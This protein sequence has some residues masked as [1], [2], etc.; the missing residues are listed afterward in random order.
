MGLSFATVS[1]GDFRV[2]KRKAKSK[3]ASSM[4]DYSRV[5]KL[6]SHPSS[7]KKRSLS[8]FAQSAAMKKTATED[9]AAKQAGGHTGVKRSTG[10]KRSGKLAKKQRFL[11]V[12]VSLPAN[13][14]NGWI[15]KC[16]Y[17]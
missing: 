7:V 6:L 14:R 11:G 2:L 3:R 16:H 10:M 13:I 12:Y 5:S 1:D 4:E 15:N 9:T 17:Q 8:S